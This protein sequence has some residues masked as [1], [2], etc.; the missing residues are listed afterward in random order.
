MLKK[1]VKCVL[2]SVSVLVG[3][4]MHDWGRGEHLG[5]REGGRGA[6]YLGNSFLGLVGV[7][8]WRS[9]VQLLKNLAALSRV[10]TL[11]M[12]RN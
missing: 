8:G 5:Q 6:G 11:S 9:V 2:S 3:E 1:S 7:S 4:R 12:E 10:S